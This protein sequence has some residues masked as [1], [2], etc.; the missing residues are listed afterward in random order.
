MSSFMEIVKYLDNYPGMRFLLSKRFNQ[1]PI[2]LYF[3]KHRQMKGGNDNPTVA[4]FNQNS[5]A[6]L[7]LNHKHLFQRLL[8]I[9]CCRNEKENENFRHSAGIVTVCYLSVIWVYSIFSYFFKSLRRAFLFAAFLDCICLNYSIQFAT[10][11][12]LLIFT[13]SLIHIRITWAETAEF[14]LPVACSHC[15]I[16]TLSLTTAL[17]TGNLISTESDIFLMHALRK[18]FLQ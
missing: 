11:A 14:C 1:D 5:S 7:S 8:K 17:S 13:H 12:W 15:S 16:E 2:E 3:G 6:L 10:N 9:S 4:Q 18:C